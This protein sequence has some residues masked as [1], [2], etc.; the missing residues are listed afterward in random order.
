VN[1]PRYPDNER[2]ATELLARIGVYN[3]RQLIYLKYTKGR[4]IETKTVPSHPTL[5]NWMS[6]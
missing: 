6:L 3:I 1:P 2:K 5:M 4:D